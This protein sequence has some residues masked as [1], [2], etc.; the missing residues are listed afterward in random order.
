MWWPTA[1]PSECQA[2]G[3]GTGQAKG[4]ASKNEVEAEGWGDRP[5]GTEEE[6]SR[7]QGLEED[8]S[9]F[10]FSSAISYVTLSK[11]MVPHGNDP[12]MYLKGH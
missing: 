8:K 12:G 10:K 5:Q 7:A 9:G 3:L 6:W 11:L 2:L 4:W 1:R